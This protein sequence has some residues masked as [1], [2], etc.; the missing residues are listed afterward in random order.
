[1]C[2]YRTYS[3]ATPSLYLKKKIVGTSSL[4]ILIW[5]LDFDSM[6]TSISSWSLSSKHSPLSLS[7]CSFFFIFWVES[8]TWSMFCFRSLIYRQLCGWLL[9][10]TIISRLSMFNLVCSS[11]Y[12]SLIFLSFIFEIFYD[13]CF[14]FL[15][16]YWYWRFYVWFGL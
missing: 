13:L 3:K 7:R 15:N 4:R 10:W 2:W 1:M 14:F 9:H 6:F 5:N 16:F 8:S 11:L 12:Y